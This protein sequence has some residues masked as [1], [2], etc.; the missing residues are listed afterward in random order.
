M[1]KF[2]FILICVQLPKCTQRKMKNEEAGGPRY[3]R[4]RGERRL[5]TADVAHMLPRREISR[6]TDVTRESV[7]VGIS[8][9]GAPDQALNWFFSVPTRFSGHFY[10]DTVDRVY[11]SMPTVSGIYFSC[12]RVCR[13]AI[14]C[15]LE[16]SQFQHFSRAIF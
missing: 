7:G 5:T 1:Y 16:K 4:R 3:G 11:Y 14:L 6:V 2:Y 9:S 8:V 13:H 12:R 15:I 10:T